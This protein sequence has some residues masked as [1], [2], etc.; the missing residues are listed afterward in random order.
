MA[1]NNDQSDSKKGCYPAGH[2]CH[3]KEILLKSLFYFF[4]MTGVY[5]KSFQ[6]IC[7]KDCA[8]QKAA[9]KI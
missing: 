8:M 4:R 1:S 2:F 6:K 5:R 7:G 9:Q 3:I